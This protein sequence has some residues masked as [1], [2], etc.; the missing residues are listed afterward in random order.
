VEVADHWT[1][2][3][4]R[5]N[6]INLMDLAL[7]FRYSHQYLQSINTCR[8]YLQVI[9]LSDL[10]NADGKRLLPECLAGQ[11]PLDRTSTLVWPLNLSQIRHPGGYGTSFSTTYIAMVTSINLSGSG[12]TNRIKNGYGIQLMMPQQFINTR[13]SH[14]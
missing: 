13:P 6:D 11:Q 3:L 9:T 14:K 1:P 2:A 7:T 12:S 8:I 10:S 5:E 4:Y